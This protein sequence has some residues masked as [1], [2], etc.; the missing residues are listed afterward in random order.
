MSVN[1]AIIIGN[2]GRDPELKTTN[3]GTEVCKFSVATSRKYRNKDGA[4]VDDTT[5]HNV[6]VW[7][8]QATSC[9]EYLSKGRPV[10]VEG[11]IHNDSYEKDGVKRYTSEIVADRVQFLGRKGDAP[12]SGG[13]F[14]DPPPPDEK[15]NIPF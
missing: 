6:T 8:K 4:M 12:A 5:W 2:L 1:K 10:Y 15:D 13:D 3:S 9:A 7:G 14:S 11:R